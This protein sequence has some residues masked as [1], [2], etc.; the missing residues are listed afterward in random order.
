MEGKGWTGKRG[1]STGEGERLSEVAGG[2]ARDGDGD[3]SWKGWRRADP[4]AAEAA[5]GQR[6]RWWRR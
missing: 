1:F 4:E 6:W 5:Q 2:R 3:G